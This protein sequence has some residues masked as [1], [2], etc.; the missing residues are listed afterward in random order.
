[1]S[2]G[3]FFSLSLPASAAGSGAGN[4]T[5]HAFSKLP[6]NISAPLYATGIRRSGSALLSGLA[7]QRIQ[8]YQLPYC[9]A[10]TSWVSQLQQQFPFSS[11][12]QQPFVNRHHRLAYH[13]PL[14]VQ[15]QLFNYYFF[16]AIFFNLTSHHS[17]SLLSGCCFIAGCSYRPDWPALFKLPAHSP[18]RHRHHFQI[19][20]SLCWTNL[21]NLLFNIYW[22]ASQ[23]WSFS[24]QQA[25]ST[26]SHQQ[27]SNN[28]NFLP[29][30]YRYFTNRRRGFIDPSS[31]CSRCCQLLHHYYPPPGP[32][33]PAAVYQ[34]N[35]FFFFIRSR[36]VQLPVPAWIQL[37]LVVVRHQAAHFF[38]FF[39]FL[40]SH[41]ASG[42]GGPPST[43]SHRH[44]HTPLCL[45]SSALSL[46]QL[47]S[48]AGPLLLAAAR[49]RRVTALAAPL[50][51]PASTTPSLA[52]GITVQDW[53]L[54]PA[55]CRYLFSS[56]SR[57]GSPPL[58]QLLHCA[59]HRRPPAPP[60]SLPLLS[61]FLD[62]ISGLDW[63]FLDSVPK[64]SLNCTVPGS[65]GL[66]FFPPLS[67]PAVFTGLVF[68]S[69]LVLNC[70]LL[71]FC[72]V[73]YRI[74]FPLNFLS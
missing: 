55:I 25:S 36:R 42:A 13:L 67:S 50:S 57:C 20:T 14:A 32:F 47:F 2:S 30:I 34:A 62:W 69:G 58:H 61:V 72:T 49:V 4:R 1:M 54:F 63:T 12:C 45:G 7:R 66:P 44:H 65:T 51:P 60:G 64:L 28:F 39:F 22:Q 68:F 9:A 8:L 38:I 15:V 19:S 33:P 17:T 18:L 16:P 26:T 10:A 74:L 40:T 56:H 3:R 52:I 23:H 5:S 27:Q 46:R 70:A 6:S 73:P 29:I 48:Q 53:L 59:R 37:R 21:F 43:T 35:F 31:N 71:D 41:I 11:G 24:I